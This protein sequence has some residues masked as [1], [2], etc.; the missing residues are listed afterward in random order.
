MLTAETAPASH[1]DS[2]AP[3]EQSTALDLSDRLFH[4]VRIQQAAHVPL[5][6]PRILDVALLDMN[7]GWPNLGHDS[8]V[9]SLAELAHEL[10]PLLAGAGLKVRVLSY[11]VR[12]G[13]VLPEPPG[14]RFQVYVGSGGPGHLDPRNNNGIAPGSQGVAED[15][16][17]EAPAFALFDAIAAHPEAALIGICHSYGVMCRWAGIAHARFR[18]EALGGKS[19]GVLENLLTD[20]ALEH[21]WF[22]RLAEQLPEQRRMRILDTRYFDLVPAR[23]E[24]PAGMTALAYETHGIGGPAGE[25][26]TMVEFARDGGG[27]M[28]RLL[29]MNHHPEIGERSRQIDILERKLRAG[30][31]TQAWHDE[32]SEL[33]TRSYPEE[34]SDL[35]LR[36]TSEYTFLGPVRFH[37]RKMAEQRA[38]ALALATATPGY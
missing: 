35:L 23:G 3:V 37:L 26:L 18:S 33:M 34:D 25:A 20:A 17:W 4:A 24:L 29:G 7:Y 12:A 11:E 15:P 31:V 13:G 8:I 21:P 9:R 1:T 10:G 27:E 30:E 5:A 32:R 22:R 6:Q 36:L 2:A 14:G 38:A 28:P 16:S 19:T